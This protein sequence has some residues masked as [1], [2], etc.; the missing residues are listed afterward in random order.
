MSYNDPEDVGE[1]H[2]GGF[3]IKKQTTS[4]E[5]NV[6]CYIRTEM[7]NPSVLPVLLCG[8]LTGAKVKEGDNERGGGKVETDEGL[9]LHYTS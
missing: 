1:T 2:F 7:M 3:L 9:I 8:S 4:Q 6:S 5:D